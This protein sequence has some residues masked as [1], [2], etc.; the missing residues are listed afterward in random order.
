MARKQGSEVAPQRR[1]N[2]FKRSLKSDGRIHLMTDSSYL[3]RSVL[4]NERPSL[5]Y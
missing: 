4:N 5:I 3:P 1:I 2:N